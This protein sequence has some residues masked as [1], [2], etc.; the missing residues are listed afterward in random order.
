MGKPYLVFLHEGLRCEAMWEG[1]PEVLCKTTGCRGLVYDRLGY[2]RVE[3]VE[4]CGHA[5][6]LETR[7]V[8]LDLMSDFI[9][10]LMKGMTKI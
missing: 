9:A 10:L 6:H 7:S 1:F 3:I 4:N 2:G 5:P 8:V